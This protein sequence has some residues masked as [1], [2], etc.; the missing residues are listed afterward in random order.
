LSDEDD[1]A[2]GESR[3]SFRFFL[4]VEEGDETDDKEVDDEVDEKDARCFDD[5]GE[6]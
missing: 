2:P 1:E 6:L 4:F 3:S 5:E